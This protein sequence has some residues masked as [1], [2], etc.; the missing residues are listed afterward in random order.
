MAD[1]VSRVQRMFQVLLETLYSLPVWAAVALLFVPTLLALFTRSPLTI[2]SAALL[3]LT[4]LILL[5]ADPNHAAVVPIAAVTWAASL[6]IVLFGLRERLLWQNLSAL[7]TRIGHMDEQMTAFLA[8]LEKRSDI[9]DE[10]TDEARSAF[11]ET[12]QAYEELRRAP[13]AAKAPLQPAPPSAPPAQ[14]TVTLG[15][16]PQKITPVETAAPAIAAPAPKAEP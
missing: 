2:V 5:G 16:L 9:L 14:A 7:E 13:Q 10:R 3:N 6:V 12:R 15:N 1:L 11:R 8:A 4:C